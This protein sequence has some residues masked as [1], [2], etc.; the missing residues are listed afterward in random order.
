MSFLPYKKTIYIVAWWRKKTT[1]ALNKGV[2]QGRNHGIGEDNDIN[3][4]GPSQRGI[5]L[6]V[7]PKI[8]EVGKAPFW[9]SITL[10]KLM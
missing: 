1:I 2:K 8:G 10:T 4:G 6:A 3:G 9:G 5:N 7:T